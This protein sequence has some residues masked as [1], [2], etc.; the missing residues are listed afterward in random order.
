MFVDIYVVFDSKLPPLSEFSKVILYRIWN[1]FQMIR[2]VLKF[3]SPVASL[4]THLCPAC[5]CFPAKNERQR[6]I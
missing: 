1:K 2:F 4:S 6:N 5:C 3:V